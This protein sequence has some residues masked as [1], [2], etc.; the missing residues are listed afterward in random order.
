[1]TL[2]KTTIDN[3]LRYVPK[4]EQTKERDFKP[5]TIKASSL[6]RQQNK[7]F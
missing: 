2:G 7:T 6:P 1:M 5:K 4:S 3:S